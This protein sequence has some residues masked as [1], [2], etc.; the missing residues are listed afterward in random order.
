[1][2][3]LGVSISHV[4][5]QLDGKQLCWLCTQAYK[6][7]LMKAK[8]NQDFTVTTIR[9]SASSSS[10]QEGSGNDSLESRINRYIYNQLNWAVDYMIGCSLLC[11]LLIQTTLLS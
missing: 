5:W 7:A 4:L 3:V 11:V 6:R 1:M 2:C 8:K 10:L 9:N